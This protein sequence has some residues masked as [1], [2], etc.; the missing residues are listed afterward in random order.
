[1]RRWEA[2]PL[3][4]QRGLPPL[5]AAVLAVGIAWASGLPPSPALLVLL[6]L[7]YA[8]Y[9]S[10]HRVRRWALPVTALSVAVA[11][12][13]YLEH[14]FALP[15][16]KSFPS[17]DTM[18]VMAIFTMM[19]LGLN[20]VVGYAGLL[21][22]GYVAF[23]AIGAYVAAWLASDHFTQV[24]LRFGAIGED[25]GVGGI[26][27]SIWLALVIAACVTAV[28]G[29][30]IGLPTLRLRGDYLAIVT[31]AFGEVIRVVVNNLDKPINLTNG[32]QGIR[33]IQR[34]PLFFKPALTALG[35]T[36]EDATLYALYFYFLVLLVVGFAVVLTRRLENSWVGRAWTAIREDELAAQ[37]MGIPLVRMK[38]AAFAAGASFAGAMGMIFGAKQYFINPESFTFMESIGVLAMVI[39]GGMGS[40]PG[41]IVGA[42]VVTILNLQVLKGLSLLLNQ[43]RAT[44]AVIP[45]LNYPLSRWPTQLDPA[46]YERLIFGILLIIMSILR[47]QGIIPERRHQLELEERRAEP[48]PTLAPTAGGGG[49]G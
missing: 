1:R 11:Y 36:V 28:A 35:V 10:P 6:A 25:T 39:V 47:P 13:F 32:P 27:I 26:H 12:P 20:M 9:L 42:T 16:V 19:A 29:V 34:P 33:A 3:L 31:L 40:L 4:L 17:M 38:L 22:L 37:A 23:Y 5:V 44:D 48:A 49:D 15:V 43:L 21:D 30:I 18:V 14:L 8:L 45:I 2:K 24:D 41:A 7:S 46:K